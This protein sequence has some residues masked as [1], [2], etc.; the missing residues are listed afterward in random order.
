MGNTIGFSPY[1][2]VYGKNILFPIEFEIKKL[3]TK[4]QVN[5]D[6]EIAQ[7]QWLNQLNEQDEKQLISIQ[8]TYIVQQQR[9]RWHDKFIKKKKFQKGDWDLLYDSR[10]RDFKVKLCTRWLSPYEFDTVF[11]NGTVNLLTIKS[12]RTPL[13][14]NGHCLQPY[15]KPA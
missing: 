5:L 7:K 3:R 1:E 4:L 12:A 2:L 9:A 11:D 15:H 10:Y 13:F 6:L 8:Q 14:A